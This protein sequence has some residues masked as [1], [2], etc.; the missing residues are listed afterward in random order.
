MTVL[1]FSIDKTLEAW[2]HLCYNFKYFVLSLNLK[3]YEDKEFF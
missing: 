3:N 1:I 2:Y